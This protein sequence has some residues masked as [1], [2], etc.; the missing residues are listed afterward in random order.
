VKIRPHKIG[1]VVTRLDLGPEV[2]I[3]RMVEARSGQVVVV[4]ALEEKRVYDQIEIVGGRMAHVGKGDVIVG[5]LGRRDALRGF[6]GV[7][8][9]QVRAGDTLHLLN[10]GGLVGQAVSEA[11]D[12][13]HPL[14]CEVLGMAVRNGRGLNVAD[15]A[16]PVADA[17]EDGCPPLLVVSGTCMNSGK[18]VACCEVIAKLTAR[19]YACAGLKMT[20]VAAQKDLLNMQDHGALA[21]LSFLD[22]GLPSTAGVADVAPVAKGLLAAIRAQV[23]ELDAIVVEMGDGIIGAYGVRTVLE[24]AQF[25]SRIR[26][27]VLCANDLVAAWGGLRFLSDLGL[28]VDVM[29]GPATDN[30]VGIRYIED[31]LGVPAA[32]AR[33]DPD[34][35]VDLVERKAFGAGPAS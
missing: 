4:R 2:E 21:S 19:G 16:L 20:G 23:P 31:S 25:R 32:N 14:R 5:A 10:L 34:R 18:T 26:A 30:D 24:D 9:D 22:C 33:V 29:A 6:Q 28:G 11:K 1:S 12:F 35:F 8:P 13:G 15:A 7:V 17:I 3:S 27:H